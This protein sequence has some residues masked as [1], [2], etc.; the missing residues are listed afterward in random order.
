MLA[1]ILL[2]AE[3][4]AELAGYSKTSAR[5]AAERGSSRGACRPSSK[6][7]VCLSTSHFRLK[8][9]SDCRDSRARAVPSVRVPNMSL[10]SGSRSRTRSPLRPARAAAERVEEDLESAF[11]DSDSELGRMPGSLENADQEFSPFFTR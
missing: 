11:E 10:R 7:T 2:R 8:L 1:E 5:L 4:A 3:N 6:S 9:I